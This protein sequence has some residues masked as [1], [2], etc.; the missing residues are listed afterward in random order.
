MFNNVWLKFPRDVIS[1][2][3]AMKNLSIFVFV[4][5]I[6]C[7]LSQTLQ[8]RPLREH[9]PRV[10]HV[11]LGYAGR[12]RPD[13]CQ[14][15]KESRKFQTVIS[16]VKYFNS[17]SPPNR[18]STISIIS[19]P[20]CSQLSCCW[21]SSRTASCFTRGRSAARRSTFSTCSLF[22]FHSLPSSSSEFINF[23]VCLSV[24]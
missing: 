10:H 17:I 4:A 7:I 13:E 24:L 12:R 11:L 8:S 23:G 18:F 14:P 2:D 5:Q 21:N 3:S 20:R 19:S 6:P 9:H 22:A 15:S 16:E 1:R